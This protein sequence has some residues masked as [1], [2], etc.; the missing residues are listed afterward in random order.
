MN[1]SL[2]TESS[3]IFRFIVTQKKTNE[4]TKKESRF[5]G[6]P[7]NATKSAQ[8]RYPVNPVV[9]QKDP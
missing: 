8:Q 1:S 9:A 5:P 7:R 6:A 2:L 4:L 3:T